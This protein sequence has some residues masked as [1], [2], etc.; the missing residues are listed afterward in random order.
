MV[1]GHQAVT[2]PPSARPD[3]KLDYL[4]AHARTIDLL[5][6]HLMHS[7]SLACSPASTLASMA[8]G[9]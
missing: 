8:G 5:Y 7:T 1:T 4:A 2:A 9:C 3:G 6:E